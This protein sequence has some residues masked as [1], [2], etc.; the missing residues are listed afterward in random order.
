M[1][2]RHRRVRKRQRAKR[3]IAHRGRSQKPQHV[4][5]AADMVIVIIIIVI[6]I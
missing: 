1:A 5:Q 2:V 3:K 6:I 4:T